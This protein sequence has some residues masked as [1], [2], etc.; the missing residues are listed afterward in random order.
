MQS[1]GYRFLP[2]R[3]IDVEPRDSSDW[4][5]HVAAQDSHS[6]ANYMTL[7]H[8]WEKDPFLT[9]T[10]ASYSSLCA[11]LQLSSLPRTFQ[12]AILV[13]RKFGV[14]F[15][16]ID[17]L[18]IFQDSL[19]DWVAE[20]AKMKDVYS[21]SYCALA[22]NWSG[23][24]CGGCFYDRN[25][26]SIAPTRVKVEWKGEK[27]YMLIDSHLWS[28]CIALAPLNSRAW[29]LQEKLLAPRVLHFGKEQIF[30]ECTE[31]LACE[32]Y[33]TGMPMGMKYEDLKTGYAML[34]IKGTATKDASDTQ[35]FWYEIVEVYSRCSL[36]K[37][38]DKL[39]ALSGIVQR[40][41]QITQDTYLAGL[42]E[43]NLAPQLLWYV[44]DYRKMTRSPQYRAPSWSWACLDGNVNCRFMRNRTVFESILIGVHESRTTYILGLLQNALI[45]LEGRLIPVEKFYSKEGVYQL[46]MRL[47]TRLQD[48]RLLPDIS[49][50]DLEI[51]LH[52]LPI[53]LH[54]TEHLRL[55]VGLVLRRMGTDSNPDRYGRHG[56]FM[57]DYSKSDQQS[58]VEEALHGLK[59]ERILLV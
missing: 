41:E 29:A 16:W 58:G 10:N 45:R 44:D 30:W 13:T 4:R 5:L 55:L 43:R 2:T 48:A 28:D 18:C 8:R 35:A 23:P 6:N 53:A 38:M 37:P 7:S 40:F 32:T 46:T 33:P 54:K 56:L 34:K 51:H 3:V 36:T 12:E 27:E 9:L 14:R 59:Q 26:R 25:P 24:S 22:A 17:S 19:E 1:K 57:L 20:S 42:W 11:G 21:N 49:P 15:L 39:M 31:K 47:G 52:C 50:S